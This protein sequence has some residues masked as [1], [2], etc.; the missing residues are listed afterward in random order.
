MSRNCLKNGLRLQRDNLKSVFQDCQSRMRNAKLKLKCMYVQQICMTH[1][2]ML[3]H[4]RFM[5]DTH[6][7]YV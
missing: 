6:D 4:T 3:T 5:K 7:G 1:T 2:C